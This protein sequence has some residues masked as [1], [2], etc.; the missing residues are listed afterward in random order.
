MTRRSFDDWM[1]RAVQATVE[2]ALERLP[3]ADCASAGRLHEAMR[4]AVLDGGKRVR[5]LLVLAAGEAVRRRC[6]RR[7]LRA[8]CAVELIHAYSLVHDDMPCMDDDVLRRGK[9]TVHVQFGEARRCSPATRCR[10]WRS[11]C[12]RPTAQRRRRRCRR[13]CAALLARAAG[14]AG[15]AGGQAIDLAS[16]GLP[17]DA[18]RAAR[19]APTARPARCCSASVLMGAACGERR[20]GAARRRWPTTA[21]P[22]AWPSRWSTTSSTSTAD[23]A[24]LGKTAGK[25]AAHNKPTYVSRA[26]PGARRARCADELRDEAHAALPRSRPARRAARCARSPTWSCDRDSLNMPMAPC[27]K[28]STTRP[29]CGKLSRA[30]LKPLAD[31]LRALRAR[32]GVADRRPPVVEPRHGRADDR[33]ALRLQHAATTASSG[34]SATRPIRTRSSPAGASAWRTLRQ[35]GGISRLSAPRRERVRHL[36][37]RAFVD[38]DL[39]RARHGGGGQ[40]EGREPQCRRG[41]RRRRDERRHGVRGAE[42]RRRRRDADL[43]VILNDNDMSISPPVGALNRYLARLMS[44]QVLR[45]RAR[46]SA[47]RC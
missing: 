11:R 15:M 39:G 2:Q 31:E 38:L 35:L 20:R 7:A 34:T 16:V 25:D 14:H 9:P 26:R 43:L 32:L 1:Q 24:T 28:R 36:R 13:A 21:T 4:Y 45:R 40:A 37:H 3:A 33:A 5:P 23:S 12:W 29:T 42:Q 46:T 30:Q 41:D 27:S 17:L 22:S 6:A 19:H 8:A 18:S 44:G 10:R 47:R